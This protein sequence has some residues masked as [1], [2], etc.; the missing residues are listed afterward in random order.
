MSMVFSD[1]KFYQSIRSVNPIF[2]TF[3]NWEKGKNCFLLFFFLTTLSLI[4]EESVKWKN[5]NVQK[6]ASVHIK[7]ALNIKYRYQI[8][9]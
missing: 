1:A 2:Y 3:C 4:S 6:F 5:G 9:E 7:M 8:P